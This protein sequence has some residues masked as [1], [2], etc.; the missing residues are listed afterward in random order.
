VLDGDEELVRNPSVAYLPVV[1]RNPDEM[2][3]GQVRDT[4]RMQFDA[5]LRMA[6][7]QAMFQSPFPPENAEALREEMKEL[8]AM[9]LAPQESLGKRKDELD[10]QIAT[11]R[12]RIELREKIQAIQAQP[13]ASRDAA[14]LAALKSE[15]ARAGGSEGNNYDDKRLVS[16]LEEQR[17]SAANTLE[18]HTDRTKDERGI[19]FT[20]NVS[21]VSDL[22]HSLQLSIEM[23]DRGEGDGVYQVYMSDITTPDSGEA[24][25][26]APPNAA[27][28]RVEAIKNGLKKLLES[29]SDYGRGRVAVE[30]EGMIHLVQ[31]QAGTG[32]MLTEAVESAAM[33]G[34]L[35]A[36]IAAPFTQGASLYLLLPLGAIGAIPSAYRLYQRYDEN[37]LRMDFAAVMDVVNIV[38]GVLGLAQAATPLR[39]VRLGQV[40]M[41]MGI[42]ADGA[43]ILMMGAGI[44]IQLDALRSLPEHERAAKMLE[45]LGQAFLQVG[46][47]AG[48]MAM[49]A[50]YQSHRTGAANTEPKKSGG[51]DEPGFHAP[52]KETPPGEITVPPA[53]GDRSMAGSPPPDGSPPAPKAPPA[54]DV[55][56]PATAAPKASPEHLFDKLSAGVDRSLPPPLPGDAINKP[57]KSG[58]YM[59]GLTTADAAYAAYNRALLASNGK[60]VAIYHNP[61]TGEYR[62]MVGS[63]VG[64]RAPEA[65]GW[66]AVLHYHPNPGNVLT[67]RLPAPQDFRGLMMRYLAEGVMVREFLEFDIPGVGRGR[68]EFGIDPANAEPFYVRIH[69]PDG[70]SRMLRFANDG[71]YTA[72]WGD[73]TIAVPK[74][75]PVYEAMI[76]DI[77]DYLRSTG[78][79]TRGDFGPPAA[80]PATPENAAPGT[81]TPAAGNSG[82]GAAPPQAKSVAGAA[83]PAPAP[84]ALQTGM[85]DLTDAGVKFIRDHFETT[86]DSSGKK[87]VA[88]SSLSDAEI[89]DKFKNQPNWLEALVL[90]EARTDWLGRSS[91]TDFLMSNPRQDFNLVAK[92]LAKAAAKGKTGHSVHDAILE[93]SVKD[94]VDEMLR[95]NDPDLT[96]AYNLCENNPDPAFK[97]R[98]DEFKHSPKQGD[99]SGFFLGKVG[100]KRPDMVEVML[101]Q[102]TIHIAD[103]TFAYQDPI[104]NFK[105]AFYKTVL[106]RLINVKT[107]TSTDYRAPFKQTPL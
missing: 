46:I 104:H 99:L 53:P 81:K 34:S 14:A 47:Q 36:I 94:F 106:E 30:V 45:I 96:A 55:Q 21:F 80:K 90:A 38:G 95:Q 89:R 26:T 59:R 29:S 17:D 39:A 77:K 31:I 83:A 32:R 71:H 48:G 69:Q 42:G 76:H 28:P 33:V 8:Q 49:H 100:T 52:P 44:V 54:P 82:G 1:A 43:G 79:D 70:S 88:V 92:R 10:A 58:E 15:L 78:A 9:L 87:K 64:V 51:L 105:S 40:L 22:G 107:V 72:Y 2:A 86:S 19:R 61:E 6:E 97:K 4:T 37:R 60:E 56:A 3:I 66:N 57:V 75:S 50:R 18:M 68:T 74:D 85:G 12:K 91:N 13:E 84:R 62:V 98:W 41:V 27:N 16:K 103:A 65:F 35:A 67:F 5:R 24:L 63:E 73:R 93:W 20:P 11:I 7:I 102:D 101:S 25:G 23:Y